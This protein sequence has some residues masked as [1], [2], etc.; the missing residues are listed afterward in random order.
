MPEVIRKPQRGLVSLFGNEY[1]RRDLVNVLPEGAK[2]RVRYDLH[3]A[4][5]VWLLTMGV[6]TKGGMRSPTRMP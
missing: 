4:E 1:C 6:R 2:V 3:N 5:K